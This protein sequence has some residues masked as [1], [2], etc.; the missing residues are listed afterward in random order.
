MRRSIAAGVAKINVNTDLRGAYL[1]ATAD[2]IGR[3]LDGSRLG[4]LHAA[5]VAAVGEVVGAKLR[6]FDVGG[7]T[8]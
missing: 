6:A 1:S 4:A 2:A 7:A 8:T 3:A 5:Q